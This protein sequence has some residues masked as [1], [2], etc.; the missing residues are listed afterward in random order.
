MSKKRTECDVNSLVEGRLVKR[1]ARFHHL[2]WGSRARHVGCYRIPP[3]KISLFVS[4]STKNHT[5]KPRTLLSCLLSYRQSAAMCVQRRKETEANELNPLFLRAICNL[6][7]KE[8]RGESR[9]GGDD[10]TGLTAGRD[11][12]NK[13]HG[14]RQQKKKMWCKLKRDVN[15]ECRITRNGQ[16]V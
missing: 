1:E 13:E 9:V 7:S 16:T 10:A 14:N 3:L 6:L 12:P 15:T 8:T 4:H 5:H 11:S 2:L